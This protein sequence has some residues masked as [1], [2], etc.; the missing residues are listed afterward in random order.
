M[1]TSDADVVIIGAGVLGSSV[2]MALAE[3]RCGRIVVLDA[4]MSGE[5][6]SSTLNVG[7]VRATWWWP[8]NI[9]LSLRSIEYFWT[10]REKIAYRRLGY[11]WMYDADHWLKVRRAV[12]RLN[13][14][15]LEVEVLTPSQLR[16]RVPEIDRLEGVAGATFSPL[17]GL[18]DSAK[19]KLHYQEEARA[20]GV[21]FLD[22]RYVTGIEKERGKWR[23]AGQVDGNRSWLSEPLIDQSRAIA[24]T[25]VIRTSNLVNAAGP[26]ATQVAQLYGD[27]L[28]S[29]PQRRQVFYVQHP[30][31]RFEGAGLIVD[32]SGAFIQPL[33]GGELLCGFANP[34]EPPGYRFAWDGPP[35][36]GEQVL[37]RLARRVSRFREAKL[38]RGW[39]RLYDQSPDRSGIIGRVQDRPGVFQVHSF[40][41]H[42]VMQSYAAG[43][44]LAELI[45]NGAYDTWKVAETLN[46]ERFERGQTVFETLYI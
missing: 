3:R 27:R 26:W 38:I 41:G 24:E 34:D 2:A 29:W 1:N 39:A 25:H 46:P 8:V 33:P 9:E 19:I 13:S 12:K 21:L 15:G 4:D 40:S 31:L 42:G 32:T 36:Y 14:Y 23:V 43:Q 16:G 22:R 30:Q 10:V 35:F 37:P 17:D 45:A 44:A 20:R 11:L 18:V 28:P 6:A 7:G 5:L